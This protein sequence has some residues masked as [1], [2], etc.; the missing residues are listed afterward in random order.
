M[1]RS[2]LSL[3]YHHNPIVLGISLFMLGYP[4]TVNRINKSWWFYAME[5]Y[6]APKMNTL[7]LH[8]TIWMDFINIMLTVIS[9]A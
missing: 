4:S 6:T 1:P 7:R 5:Y 8:T 2:S 9:Q 3:N